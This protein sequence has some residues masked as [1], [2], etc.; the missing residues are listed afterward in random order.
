M[1][2]SRKSWSS[3]PYAGGL[4]PVW[5]LQS[6]PQTAAGHPQTSELC[7]WH[8]EGTRLMISLC[9]ALSS[10]CSVGT[11]RNTFLFTSRDGC[12]GRVPT[13]K[14]TERHT[15]GSP[16]WVRRWRGAH[17]VPKAMTPQTSHA[18]CIITWSCLPR[19]HQG[20]QQGSEGR[21][22]PSVLLIDFMLLCHLRSGFQ[23]WHP[24]MEV[25]GAGSAYYSGPRPLGSLPQKLP[26]FLHVL[27][28][29]FFGIYNPIWT[30]I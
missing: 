25:R 22:Q 19:W 30:F 5:G 16:S 21:L 3:G 1:G 10:P 23:Q 26:L 11:R 14:E 20:W 29:I 28:K 17:V 9:R 4:P 2:P 6:D 18:A 13:E 24:A 27:P 15:P 12:F 7:W 8:P